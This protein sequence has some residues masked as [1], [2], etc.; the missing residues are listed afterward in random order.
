MDQA[1]GD[2]TSPAE[3][4]RRAQIA[5]D[6]V[7]EGFGHRL[8]GFAPGTWIGSVVRPRR[9]A[10]PWDPWHYWWQ[11]HYLD[12]LV[13][14]S[15]RKLGGPAPQRG[16][17][18]RQGQDP[19]TQ[20]QGPA[21]GA[22]PSEPR[23][24]RE[25]RLARA[26][27]RTIRIRN[28]LQYRNAFYDDMAWLALAAGRAEF[29]TQRVDER[30]IR[31]ARNA[32]RVLGAQLASANTDDLEGGLFW[33]MKRDF[34]NTPA[35]APAALH[36]ARAGDRERA[37]RLV[38]WLNARLL[39][40]EQGLYLDGLRMSRDGSTTLV[41][42]VWTYNQGP[43]LG[44]L[45]E[46]GGSANIGRA[47]DL[48]EAVDRRLTLPLGETR[49]LQANGDGDG[50]L[51]M[52]ILARYLTVAAVSSGLP[53]E[54]RFTARRLVIDTAQAVWAGAEERTD[55]QGRTVRTFPM[56]PGRPASDAYPEGRGVELSTQLQAWML[57]EF[58]HQLTRG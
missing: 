44:A 14:A 26:L 40:P 48:V 17:P 57:L 25:L 53:A 42:D 22:G 23:E 52:G 45:L 30:G 35:T 50:G 31:S 3:W 28:F 20:G 33:N 37:Q 58:A 38:D 11:A 15:W 27:L 19:A 32:A 51:F 46:L 7:N 5:A 29:L 1:R 47:A 39:D 49:V 56:H 55:G 41:K 9:V 24:P 36:F 43:V 12:C 16:G 18:A 8:L 10:L 13:D 6:S 4:A 2:Q 21:T 54:A 34:K